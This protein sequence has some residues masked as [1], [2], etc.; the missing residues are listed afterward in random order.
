MRVPQRD[1]F[2]RFLDELVVRGKLRKI[3]AGGRL[4]VPLYAL[5]NTPTSVLVAA[6]EAVDRRVGQGSTLKK[7]ASK[8]NATLPV[9]PVVAGGHKHAVMRFVTAHRV[10]I[11][12][13]VQLDLTDVPEFVTALEASGIT[14][15]V[16]ATNGD[17]DWR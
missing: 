16:A 8:E 13:S 7:N 9:P 15:A 5:E 4:R 3:H 1:A 6:Q 17:E 14:V 10:E 12:L 2:R 11:S